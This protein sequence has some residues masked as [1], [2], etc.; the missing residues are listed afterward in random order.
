MIHDIWPLR[1]FESL[2]N[3]LLCYHH[4]NNMITC[5]KATPQLA[6]SIP[7]QLV[8]P[9]P[10]YLGMEFCEG[11]TKIAG[12]VKAQLVLFPS[13]EDSQI[14]SY[15]LLPYWLKH[16]KTFLISLY[17]LIFLILLK[18]SV[19]LPNNWL[20]VW[21][22]RAAAA[23]SWWR[24]RHADGVKSTGS[25]PTGQEWIGERMLSECSPGVASP[26][27][28]KLETGDSPSR[29]N[30]QWPN[31]CRSFGTHR[32]HCCSPWQVFEIRKW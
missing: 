20:V 6:T 27:H 17:S 24:S 13:W 2:Q 4:D 11:A 5:V 29:G 30:Q 10:R 16:L 25:M 19:N 31:M 3:E 1:F 8:P 12:W 14:Y 18:T 22:L 15:H 23:E 7:H 9:A 32:A 21:C 28:L 26:W